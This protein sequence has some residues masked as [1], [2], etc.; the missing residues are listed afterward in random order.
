MPTSTRRRIPVDPTRWHATSTS[1][2]KGPAARPR[3]SCGENARR[4]IYAS[5]RAPFRTPCRIAAWSVRRF[6]VQLDSDGKEGGGSA[7][8]I[9]W[10]RLFPHLSCAGLPQVEA[11]WGAAGKGHRRDRVRAG[12]RRRSHFAGLRG[13]DPFVSLRRRR[14]LATGTTRTIASCAAKWDLTLLPAFEPGGDAS[15]TAPV[16]RNTGEVAVLQITVPMS[17]THDHVTALRAWAGRGAVRLVARTRRSV[18]RCCVGPT[19]GQRRPARWQHGRRH[20]HVP[21]GIPAEAPGIVAGQQGGAGQR[22][23]WDSNP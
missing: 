12:R 18:P 2:W 22:R 16:K 20:A 3:G 11:W 21:G 19:T 14:G 1:P 7:G 9:G 17:V 10:R 5:A 6:R 4:G 8:S 23:A 13:Q 15:R